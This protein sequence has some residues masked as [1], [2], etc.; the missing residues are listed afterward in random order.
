MTTLIAWTS[1][2]DTGVSP[3]LPRAMYVASDSRI[4]WGSASRKWEAGRKIF[5][6]LKEP[7]IFGYCGDALF[8]TL[9][10]GQI[11][12]AIDYGIL[13]PPCASANEKNEIIFASMQESHKQRHGV[14]EQ[15]FKI[16]HVHRTQN[17]PSTAFAAWVISYGAA[18]KSWNCD[19]ISLPSTTGIAIALGS[20][21]SVAEAHAGRWA[22]SDVG[23]MSRAIFSAFCDAVT[24]GNDPLSGGAPQISALYTKDPPRPLGYAENGLTFLHGL[25]LATCGTL[26]NIEWRDRLFQEIDPNTLMSI[27]GARRF[28]RPPLK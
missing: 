28:A 1:Y 3:H 23:G 27:Q 24:S 8:P 22:N 25:Q 2:S 13:F 20:G 12:S 17:W 21:A 5:A 18:A 19:Q 7:H 11:I 4:T 14:L 9:V 10:L 16:L 26:A 6:P 15:D